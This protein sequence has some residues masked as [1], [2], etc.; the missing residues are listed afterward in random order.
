MDAE[1]ALALKFLDNH[2]AEAAALL[3][4]DP[5]AT[6]ALLADECPD[7][8]AGELLRRMSADA[9]ARCLSRLAPELAASFAASLP[10][11][12]LGLILR[13]LGGDE[14]DALLGGLPDDTARAI[15][16]QLAHAPGTAGAV[17]DPTVLTLPSDVSTEE[18]S[19]RLRQSPARSTYYLYVVDRDGRLSGVLTMRDLMLAEPGST[20]ADVMATPVSALTAGMPRVAILA[21]PAWRAHPMLPV[22]DDDGHFLGVVRYETLRAL[23]HHAH[24]E[25]PGGGPSPAMNVAELVWL[26]L[27]NLIDGLGA[28]PSVDRAVGGEADDAGR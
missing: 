17:M 28:V 1:R 27:S 20:L 15:R 7:R 4:R 16:S 25:R 5:E 19:E 11:D 12:A 23:E 13:R 10:V 26:G 24:A 2:T 21:E 3:E 6:S 9:A 22:V 14:R 8:T 18:A